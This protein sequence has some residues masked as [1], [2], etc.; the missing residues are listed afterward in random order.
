MATL[1]QLSGTSWYN[2]DLIAGIYCQRGYWRI[3]LSGET[4]TITLN[5]EEA[6]TL[7]QYLKEHSNSN[8]YEMTRAH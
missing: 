7:E 4:H 5:D 8:A 3:R 2:V 6:K 1:I